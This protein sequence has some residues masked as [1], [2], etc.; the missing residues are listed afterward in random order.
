MSG[1]RAVIL[2]RQ[3]QKATTVEWP[4]CGAL[5]CETS[6]GIANACQIASSRSMPIRSPLGL[7]PR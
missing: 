1:S 5:V 2:G 7:R 3:K 4:L 6:R